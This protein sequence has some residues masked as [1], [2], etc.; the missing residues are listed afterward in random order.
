MSAATL[1]PP[2]SD[3]GFC[4]MP[5]LQPI[6][7]GYLAIEAYIEELL[8]EMEALRDVIA[9]RDRRLAR[10]TDEA[11]AD[12]KSLVSE[13]DSLQEAVS[14]REQ[15]LRAAE[16]Q[17]TAD[18]ES[19]AGERDALLATIAER[20]LQLSQTAIESA[21]DE[22]VQQNLNELLQERTALEDELET[23]RCRAAELSDTFDSRQREWH[24]EREG[25]EAEIASLRQSLDAQIHPASAPPATLPSQPP[26]VLPAA[27]HVLDSVMQ[28]F[29]MIQRDV[30][31]RRTAT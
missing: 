22:T 8:G 3:D 30:T 11:S 7:D 27:D 5:S 29:E 28:Q 4:Q 21:T 16:E 6:H 17:A 20:D 23:V 9:E 31:Q 26:A 18:I 10:T 25:H 24:D 2:T 15:R 12:V 19:L 1:P 13:R 14:E